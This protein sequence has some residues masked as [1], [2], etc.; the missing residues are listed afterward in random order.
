[1]IASGRLKVHRA[2]PAAFKVPAEAT[3]LPPG[4]L[5]SFRRLLDLDA[6]SE[7]LHGD[8]RQVAARQQMS[9]AAIANQRVMVETGYLTVCAELKR[10]DQRV[11]EEIARSG[12]ECLYV[13][14]DHLLLARRGFSDPVVSSDEILERLTQENPSIQK[15]VEETR[16]RISAEKHRAVETAKYCLYVFLKAAI[17]L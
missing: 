14:G 12:K 11:A 1:M 15:L 8:Q 2:V 10:T 7:T 4:T 13:A 3:S 17:H 6:R 5:S 9:M 16:Q